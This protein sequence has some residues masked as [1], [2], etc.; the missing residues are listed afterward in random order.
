MYLIKYFLL[1][2]FIVPTFNQEFN[3]YE[4]K[5]P[6]SN[7]TFQMAPIPGGN[8]RLG[9][10]KYETDEGPPVSIQIDS[11]WMGSHE[12]PHELFMI[13]RDPTKDLDENGQPRV[14]AVTRPSTPY[15]DPVF[16]MGTNGYP[17]AGM[18]QLAALQ[19]CRWLSDKT[20]HFY[21]LPTESEWEYACRAGSDSDY[22]FGNK[23]K[24]LKKY[25]WFEKNSNDEFHLLGQL[26]PNPWGLYDILGNV[27][28]WTLDQY[29]ADFYKTLS[30]G[31]QNPWRI[32]TQLHP[33][34]VKGGS[35]L[36]EPE[37][38]RAANRIESS[39]DWKKRDPQIPKSFWWNT[40][41]PFVGFRIIRPYR[42]PSPEDQELFWEMVLGG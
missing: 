34:T 3:S 13:F 24:D 35:Y 2:V 36:D 19:F 16:G 20:G 4:E 32:P 17:A 15:E 14:D 38:L 25:A 23:K 39:L 7:L 8:F 9:S 37:E 5:V 21:R 10:D 40:D 41:S 18:T 11:F 31:T 27:S 30:N 22:F 33:R 1:F 6:G 26:A 12:V 28:E 29:Q 42:A